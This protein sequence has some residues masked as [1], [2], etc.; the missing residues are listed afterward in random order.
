MFKLRSKNGAKCEVYA[1][2]GVSGKMLVRRELGFRGCGRGAPRV[3]QAL[4]PV[5]Q[6]NAK[7]ACATVKKPEKAIARAR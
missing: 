6:A 2:L 1:G 4:L 5:P 7:N 3:A